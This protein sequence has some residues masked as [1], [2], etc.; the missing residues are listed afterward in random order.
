MT[1][2]YASDLHL[3]FIENRKQLND[4]NFVPKA[5]IL[6]LA[7]DIVPFRMLGQKLNFIT[8]LSNSFK[9]V[10]WIP[11][12]HEYYGYNVSPSSD[13]IFREVFDNIFLINND[14]IE[15][16]DVRIICSTMWSNINPADEY[17]IQRGF[18]D[19][20]EIINNTGKKLKV[21]DYNAVHAA[22]L[23]FIKQAVAQ[24]QG[25]KIIV[26]THHL[27]TFMNYPEKYKSSVLNQCFA[28]ELFDFIEHSDIK[29]WIY[30]HTHENT[31]EF[32][33]G[34]TEMLTNQF[35]YAGSNEHK[36]FRTNAIFE[37]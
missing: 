3:E 7:G 9:K 15:I 21:D 28:V 36:T 35:G 10:Y 1:I 17:E 16:E 6:L 13:K 14:V 26:M 4:I 2:Q 29:Y 18:N 8:Y 24:K 12:N 19:F 11:G 32:K 31:L 30:G 5:D 20:H 23:A 22:D 34:N 25:K 27:P 37:I 33:I